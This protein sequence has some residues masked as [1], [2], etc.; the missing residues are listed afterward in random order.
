MRYQPRVRPDTAALVGDLAKGGES[1]RAISS[2]TVALARERLGV[3]P[4]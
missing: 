2:P 4:G 1:A 3:R